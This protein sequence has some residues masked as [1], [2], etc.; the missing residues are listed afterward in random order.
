MDRRGGLQ[1]HAAAHSQCLYRTLLRRKLALGAALSCCKL[2]CSA[3][4]YGAASRALL[5]RAMLC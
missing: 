5:G 2:D 4:E 3:Q 1:N